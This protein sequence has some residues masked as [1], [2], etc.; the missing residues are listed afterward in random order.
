LHG[1]Q[2]TDRNRQLVP[3]AYYNENSGVGLMMQKYLTDQPAK[4]AVV[5]LGIG[6]LAAYG[7]SGDQ[8][9]FYEINPE[10][11]QLAKDYFSFLT[12]SSADVRVIP[13]D[14]RLSL[15]KTLQQG[16]TRDTDILVVDAFSG[17][18]VPVHL[19]TA[20]AV[21]VYL[22]L[23]KPDGIVAI[24]ASTQHLRLIPVVVRLAEHHQIPFRIF[25]TRPAPEREVVED[26]ATWILLT[27]NRKF[28][29]D[30]EVQ[31]KHQRPT[32]K[33]AHKVSLW[34]DKFSALYEI[35]R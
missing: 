17:D 19:L 9:D 6:T 10:V 15:E 18:S 30:D 16:A 20:E 2:F 12:K 32:G 14:A 4:V 7:R 13:G 25:T 23:L 3:T 33:D 28:L 26:L 35:V 22:D 31:T 11:E 21:Q 8:F 24:H 5:G 27:H 1:I 29:D 34:T